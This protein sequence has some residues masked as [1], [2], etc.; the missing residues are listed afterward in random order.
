VREN[1]AVLEI[2]GRKLAVVGA[3]F[4]ETTH[5]PLMTMKRDAL[6]I[7]QV[8][9]IFCAA[10]EREDAAARRAFLDEACSGDAGL[11][12]KVDA[13]LAA[14]ETAEKLFAESGEALVVTDQ[15]C[16]AIALDP[17]VQAS[18]GLEDGREE[19]LG[20][21]IG[22]YRLIEPLGQGGCGVVYL[23]EQE[24]PVRRQVALKIIKLGMDTKSVIARFEA[25][26]QALAMMDHPHIAR[27]LDMGATETGRPYF[28]MDLVRGTRI[29]EFCDRNRLDIPQ[30]LKLFSQVCLAL[31]HAHQKGVIH[32]DIKPSNVLVTVHDGILR[33]VVIDFGIAKAVEGRLTDETIH[34]LHEHF[35]GTPAYMSPE[36]AQRSHRDIDTRSDIYSLGVLAY[37]LMAGRAPFDQAQLVD[38]GFD[39]M[40]RI[41]CEREPLRPSALLSGMPENARKEIARLR[42]TE[43]AKLITTL[44][45]DL[46]WIPIKAMEKDRD[47]RY[48]TANELAQDVE[49]YLND[50]PIS[51]RPPSRTYRLRK[52]V[53]RHKVVF[54]SGTMVALA[55][56][57][58]L[59]STLALLQR[60]RQLRLQA[61]WREGLGQAAALI[62]QNAY[63]E[64]DRQIAR[65][66]SPPPTSE[67][68]DLLRALGEWNALRGE[69][70]SAKERYQSL[71]RANRFE[72]IDSAS[73]DLVAGAVSMVKSGDREAYELFCRETIAS[74]RDTADPMI[75][76]RVLKSCL[77]LPASKD[78]I[79]ELRPFAQVAESRARRQDHASAGVD[80]AWRG[81]T[82]ALWKYRNGHYQEALDWIATVLAEGESPLCRSSSVRVIRAMALHQLRRTD[83]ARAE[84][85]RAREVIRAKFEKPLRAYDPDGGFWFDWVISEILL[86][87][88][89]PLIGIR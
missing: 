18:V 76:D 56:A 3:E 16:Q 78:R 5:E 65:L 17:G 6:F 88:A 74:A 43:P 35:I 7:E 34:T 26:R 81:Q 1:L 64:A 79:K 63:A 70:K 72:N 33:P 85:A 37:E 84:L 14:H 73:L 60:E 41:V 67:G 55:L 9:E 69:W 89:T 15:V 77:L 48:Q 42:Q 19:A 51:A 58:G 61:E 57:A 45:R 12:A 47:R 10:L 2:A 27:V 24:K 59:A 71:L 11:R 30:R 25:E 21:R 68:A 36:Q 22:P 4:R 83:E 31:Q 28:V 82:L 46:D 53:R 54:I 13:L 32:R 66:P 86:N 20:T 23:A 29:T 44:R 49:R 75:A 87:E 52:L 50:E 8:E 62:H 38:S 80:F 39:E 40:R